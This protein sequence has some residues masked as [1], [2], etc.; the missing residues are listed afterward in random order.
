M[1]YGQGNGS[2]NEHE[3]GHRCSNEHES[4]QGRSQDG[5]HPPT[6]EFEGVEEL[7]V[8]VFHA[9]RRAGQLQRQ[10]VLKT[11]SQDGGHHGEAFCLRALAEN[12]GATQRDIAAMLH[13]SRPRV[14]K[15]L[16]ALEAA[17]AVARRS[18]ERDRRLTRVFLTPEGRRRERQL[19]SRW[20]EHINQTVGAM[21]QRDRRE[22]IRLLDEL[23]DQASRALR[24]EEE[25]GSETGR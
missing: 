20:A 6:L 9:L 1:E 16:Q 25:S 17:G 8:Q 22:L 21:S 12:D 2:E 10:A 23:S 11:L 19:H 24:G 15:M 5:L 3:H 4:G 7:T 13:L 18:D 14:T